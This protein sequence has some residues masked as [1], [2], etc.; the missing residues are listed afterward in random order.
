M[1]LAT[2]FCA[3]LALLAA[4]VSLLSMG[5]VQLFDHFS[6]PEGSKWDW[7]S[8]IGDWIVCIVWIGGSMGFLAWAKIW[9]ANPS[10]GSGEYPLGS[11]IYTPAD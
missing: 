6:P 2:R 8:D 9:V 10:F 5:T 1:L 7:I 3:I 11:K 4:A